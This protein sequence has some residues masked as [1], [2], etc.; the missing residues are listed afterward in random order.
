MLLGL[1]RKHVTFAPPVLYP[2]SAIQSLIRRCNELDGA[3]D[4]SSLSSSNSATGCYWAAAVEAG[5]A[6]ILKLLHEHIR[7]VD[8]NRTR[9]LRLANL[10]VRALGFRAWDL[11][12][13]ISDLLRLVT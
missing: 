2:Y 11:G 1:H 5:S 12:L 4:S 3:C 6:D 13:T 7:V 8:R 9:P 10:Q